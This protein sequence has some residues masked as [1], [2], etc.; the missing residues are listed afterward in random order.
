M[1]DLKSFTF[2]IMVIIN[3]LKG[4]RRRFLKDGK[5]SFFIVVVNVANI[6]VMNLK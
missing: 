3:Y 1:K 2:C 4:A 6:F 5:F